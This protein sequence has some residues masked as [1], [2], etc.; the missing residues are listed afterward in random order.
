M[1]GWRAGGYASGDGLSSRSHLLGGDNQL[2]INVDADF[3]VDREIDGLRSQVRQLGGL[4]RE[5]HDE[6]Q[7][8]SKLMQSLEE[9]MELGR[10]ALKNA[11]KKLNRVY[12][13]AQSNHF[14]WL[15]LF[16][17]VIIIGVWFL[18]KMA[19]ITRMV[20]G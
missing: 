8:Q 19:H 12:D 15:V 3:D 13:Q 6:T 7:S 5:I 18:A 16:A 10:Q 1:S 11:M 14:L 20:I 2:Q 9:T 4:A 17:F